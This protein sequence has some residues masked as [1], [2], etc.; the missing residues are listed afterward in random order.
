MDGLNAVFENFYYQFCEV[1]KWI[2][3]IKM[4]SDIVKSGT[5][6][7]FDD[8]FRGVFAGGVGYGCL[9]SIVKI[10]DSVQATFK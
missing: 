10:L 9:Y 1:A 3:A 2:F 5:N 8:L 7:E 6:G 4:G